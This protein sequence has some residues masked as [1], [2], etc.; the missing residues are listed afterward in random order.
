MRRQTA[1]GRY[2]EI[3]LVDGSTAVYP[4]VTTV[5]NLIAKPALVPWACNLF[6]GYLRRHL[7]TGQVLTAEELDWLLEEGKRQHRDALNAAGTFGSQVHAAIEEHLRFGSWLARCDDD[8]RVGVCVEG[9]SAWWAQ[10]RLKPVEVET[11]VYSARYAFAGT[12]DLVA[13]DPDGARIL[14]DWKTS[15]ALRAESLVQA[16][17]YALA[18][19]EM[20]PGQRIDRICVLRLEKEQPLFELVEVTREQRQALFEVFLALIKVHEWSTTFKYQRR[21]GRAL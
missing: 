4:S 5:L 17:S 21:K 11:V 20:H 10:E 9:W 2:Y 1:A 13:V 14:A 12:A 6:E 19:E 7:P 15:N 3:Q 18:W 8:P 16:T